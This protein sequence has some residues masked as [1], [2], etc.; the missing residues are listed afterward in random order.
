MLT[1]KKIL[2]FLIII[3]FSSESES[4]D[5]MAKQAILFDY[6]TNSVIFEKNS[7]ELMSPSSMSKIM[8]IYYVFK[9][10][11]DGEL[12]L[13]DKFKVSK[14]SWKKGGSKMFLNVNSMVS[15]ED[16]IRG[17][18]VQSGNDA[19]IAIAEGISG[20]EELFAEELNLL[21]KEIGL[22]NS[23]FTNST[24]WPDPEHLTTIKDLLTLTIR[25]IEDFPDLYHY[26]S[27]K[28]FTYS[29]IKQL[30][31]NPLLFNSNNADGLKTGH[32]SLGGYGLVASIKK[33]NRR[34][35][36]IL[37]GLKKTRDR[38]KESERLIKIALNQ[39]KNINLFNS[40]ETIS[41]LTVWGGKK[42]NVNIY[43]KEKISITIPSK[44]KKELTYSIKHYQPIL[45][46]I[47]KDQRVAEL[48]IKKNNDEII[49]KFG[50]FAET[51]VKKISF[52]SKVY[53]NLK[54]LLLGDSLFKS[55]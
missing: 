19:C 49:K 36:L 34:L 25:T 1:I 15:V 10:I 38:T 12:K 5:T 52:F 48:I 7:E 41:N 50:L 27:E 14:K 31:R 11:K 9:K 37:N 21:A 23:N 54:Y 47:N 43:S 2:L 3:T 4:L 45:A 55:K 24:G 53:Y 39:Y 40:N 18:I 20:S 44:I 6:E 13:S 35:I 16:L 33:N 26:Y 32:T 30:N 17:I 8:T 29:G 28:E 42:K 22:T 46:P 51:E